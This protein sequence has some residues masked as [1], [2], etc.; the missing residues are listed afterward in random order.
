MR[1]GELAGRCNV[2]TD[3]VRFYEKEGLIRSDRLANGY[4]DYA[5]D[6]LVILGFIRRAQSLGFTLAEIREDVPA[7]M[8]G[9][10]P[11]ARVEAILTEKIGKI[12]ERIASLIGMRA[13]LEELLSRPCPINVE[14]EAAVSGFVRVKRS[15]RKSNGL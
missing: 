15:G 11:Q 4:R 7:L 6:M 1:I 13:D 2:S 5:E 14:C 8:S 12:D 3:T 10:L 9:V